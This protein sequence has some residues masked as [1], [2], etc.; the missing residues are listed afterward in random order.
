LQSPDPQPHKILGVPEKASKLQIDEA[1]RN[2]MEKLQP[3][4]VR[5]PEAIKV[6]QRIIMLGKI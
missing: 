5:E 1:F 6:I 3:Q 4:K 2:V